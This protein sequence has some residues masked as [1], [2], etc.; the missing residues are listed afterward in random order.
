MYRALNYFVDLTDKGRPYSVGAPYP[1]EGAPE[2][3]TERIAS[4]LGSDNKQ[5]HPLIEE[6]GPEAEKKAAEEAQ[7]AEKEAKAKAVAEKK[8]AEPKSE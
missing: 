3:S 1:A 5:G 8:A 7:R 4:L 6:V 2:P